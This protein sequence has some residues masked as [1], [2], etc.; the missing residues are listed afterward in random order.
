M[1]LATDHVYMPEDSGAQSH[2]VLLVQAQAEAFLP[3]ATAHEFPLYVGFGT[4]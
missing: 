4:C 3:L 2:T 1:P